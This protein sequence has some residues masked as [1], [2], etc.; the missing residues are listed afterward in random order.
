MEGKDGKITWPP[1]ATFYPDPK[2]EKMG[3][4]RVSSGGATIRARAFGK[5]GTRGIDL[6]RKRRRDLP[7]HAAGSLV[8]RT[9]TRWGGERLIIYTAAL[10]APDPAIRLP[11]I[12]G[13]P[14]SGAVSGFQPPRDR[15]LNVLSGPIFFFFF[16]F[17]HRMPGSAGNRFRKFTTATVYGN[18][19][20]TIIIV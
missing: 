13:G 4:R 19:V 16:F 7:R 5:S 20:T 18:N 14:A 6:S 12:P 17:C 15:I 3:A 11:G 10:P 9:E 8:D 2:M 1:G